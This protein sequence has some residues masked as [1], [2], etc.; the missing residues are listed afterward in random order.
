MV[1]F[2]AVDMRFRGLP[3]IPGQGDFCQL[4]CRT[5]VR[6]GETRAVL[7][8]SLDCPGM[9]ATLIGRHLFHLP[10]KEAEMEIQAQPGGFRVESRRVQRHGDP[11]AAFV[12]TYRPTGSAATPSAGTL[13]DFL[14]R[15]M[16]L[17]VPDPDG[18][19]IRADIGHPP[20]RLQ[21][22]DLSIEVN[23]IAEAA[24]ITLPTVAPHAAYA[25]RTDSVVYPP[26]RLAEV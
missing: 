12:A 1:P 19:L 3:P 10:F 15:R 8:L 6:L 2:K 13:D 25:A 11:A 14:T 24:G 23:T 18:R 21:P 5:Y 4:N 17:F 16:S 22:A 7:F 26:Q 20:W 9:V